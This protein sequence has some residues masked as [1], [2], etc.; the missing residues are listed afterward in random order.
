MKL[1]SLLLYVSNLRK[2]SDFYG[3]LGFKIKNHEYF[4]D[5]KLNDF[6]LTLVDQ[7]K[8]VFKLESNIKS[9]GRGVYIYLEVN[10]ID[11][12]FKNLEKKGFNPSSK[13]RNWPWGNREFALRDPDRYVLIFSQKLNS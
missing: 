9:K 13:P 4:A 8:A 7:N 3:N 2:S 12:F 11:D 5:A 1:N 10:K 6:V